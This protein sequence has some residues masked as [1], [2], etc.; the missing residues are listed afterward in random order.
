MHRYLVLF[1]VHFGKGG[2]FWAGFSKLPNQP[3]KGVKLEASYSFSGKW[4]FALVFKLTLTTM[5]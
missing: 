4:D 2:E 1:N 5:S 3:K